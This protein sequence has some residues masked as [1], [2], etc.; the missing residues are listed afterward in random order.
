M[1]ARWKTLTLRRLVR[2]LGVAAAVTLLMPTVVVVAMISIVGIPL[3]LALMLAPTLFFLALGATAGRRYAGSEGL[4]P[5][6]AGAATALLVLAAGAS[7]CNGRLDR[8]AA[9]LMSADHDEMPRP[10]PGRTLALLTR[11]GWRPSKDTSPCGGLCQRLLLS[12]AVEQFLVAE[13]PRDKVEWTA[14]LPAQAFRLEQRDTCPTVVVADDSNRSDIEN[15]P[16]KDGNGVVT[17]VGGSA[18]PAAEM[19]IAIASGRCLLQEAATLADADVVL[20]A[21]NVHRGV[22]ESGA[23]LNPGA[24][25]VRAERL[26]VSRRTPDGFAE[27]YRWTGVRIEKHP[28]VLLATAVGG[29]GELRMVAGFGR[30]SVR[31]GDRPFSK[32]WDGV[33]DL[34]LF[35]RDEAGLELR[36]GAEAGGASTDRIALVSAALDRN[37]PLTPVEQ[38]VIEDL[39]AELSPWGA[40][41]PAAADAAQPDH[42]EELRRAAMRALADPRV[43]AP[44]AT[45]EL[46]RA[47]KDRGDAENAALADVLFARLATTDP[48]LREDHPS[49]LEWPLAYLANA[50]AMLPP[51]AVLAHRE[52][53]ERL[54]RD[55]AARARAASALVQLSAFGDDAVPTLLMV[56]DESAKAKVQS[57]AQSKGKSRDRDTWERPNRVALAALCAIGSNSA[58]VPDALLERLRKESLPSPASNAELLVTIFVKAGRDPEALRPWLQVDADPGERKNFD[59]LVSRARSRPECRP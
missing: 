30:R 2:V 6:L 47:T 33:P 46:V 32:S 41:K 28:P 52:S 25:T 51:K 23:G 3:G 7:W 13:L 45:Y 8:T 59:R 58:A 40:P 9:E 26:T 48:A 1:V 11:S 5:A 12:G 55:S 16:R 44:R 20:L 27:C 34:G 22:T 50:I 14:A 49:Y 38:R 39:F 24:D 54:A 19:R 57:E 18:S 43:T 53:L 10:L 42:R 15:L 36:A 56:I 29:G 31:L 4:V 17:S 35:L 37:G 21:A